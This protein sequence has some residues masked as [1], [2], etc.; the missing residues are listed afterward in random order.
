MKCPNPKCGAILDA[1]AVFCGNCG[2]RVAPSAQTQAPATE[3]GAQGTKMWEPQATGVVLE[4]GSVFAKRYD[5]ERMIGAGGMGSVYLARDQN[6]LERVALKLLHRDLFKGPTAMARLA[7]EGVT[8]RQIRHPN[9][10]A[11]YDVAQDN[12]QP[13]MSM[14]Y[15]AGGSLRSWLGNVIRARKDVPVATAA[16]IIKAILS[17][18]AEAHRMQVIHR[19]LKPENVLLQGDPLAGDFRLKILDFGIAK[20]TTVSAGTGSQSS[21]GRALGTPLYMAPEQHTAP[22]TVGPPADL[23]S[24]SV[25]LYELLM[26]TPPQGNSEM[27]S[28]SRKDVPK[29]LDEV[30]ARGM[31]S[32]HATAFSQPKNMPQRWMRRWPLNRSPNRAALGK[33][34]CRAAPVSTGP[35]R[36]ETAT[37]RSQS[38]RFSRSSL[39]RRLLRRHLAATNSIGPLVQRCWWWAG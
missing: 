4:Q 17:G 39:A 10:V 3:P 36:A 12:G 35:C 37:H 1:D 25:M 31:S 13:Y 2:E 11:V 30:I 22:D 5:I 34:L 7:A 16:G 9:I 38:R 27:P 26:E 14:E 29:A 24:V 15:V 8:A 32:G 19:D 28:L 23:Y 6:T 33:N 21:T 18:L 20:V